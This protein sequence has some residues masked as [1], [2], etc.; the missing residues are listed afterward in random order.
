MIWQWTCQL[1]GNKTVKQLSVLI[2]D[3]VFLAAH[4]IMKSLQM[5]VL[6]YNLQL[7]K[8]NYNRLFIYANRTLSEFIYK[9]NISLNRTRTCRPRNVFPSNVVQLKI[10]FSSNLKDLWKF[11]PVSR[12]CAEAW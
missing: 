11:T 12:K 6:Q 5:T 3:I 7:T 1:E 4:P 8:N 2:C 9:V 10:F